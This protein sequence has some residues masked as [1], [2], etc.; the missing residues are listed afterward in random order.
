MI[1][2]TPLLDIKTYV[3][4]YDAFPASRAGWMEH[5]ALKRTHAD[6]RFA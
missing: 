3:P 5:N 1:D 4:E 2:G 6:N